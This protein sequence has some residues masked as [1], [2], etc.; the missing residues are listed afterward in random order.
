MRVL[1][2][3]TYG[4]SRSVAVVRELHAR[5]HDAVAVGWKTSGD[6]LPLLCAWASRI[7]VVQESMRTK[8]LTIFQDRVRVFEL[9]PDIWSNPYHPDLAARVREILERQGLS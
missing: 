4:H 9:G 7:I 6:A 3:C 5:G 2:V 8:I 1:A